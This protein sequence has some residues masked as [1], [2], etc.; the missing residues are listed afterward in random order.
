MRPIKRD[1]ALAAVVCTVALLNTLSA[2][3]MP[4]AERRATPLVALLWLGLLL[5]HGAVYELGNRIR[6]RFH[7]SGYAAAQATILFAIA[8][9]RPPA[10]LTIVLFMTAVADLVLASLI[11]S[12]LYRAT[13]NGLILAA[14]GL[15]AHAIAGLLHRPEGSH[16]VPRGEPAGVTTGPL[17]LSTREH[18]VLQELVN[19]A[20]NSD[21][22]GTL[23][24]TERTVKAHLG[25]I[26]RKLG[27]E[28][29][30]AA[31]AAAVQ[32]GLSPREQRDRRPA[33]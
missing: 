24:I 16:A 5:V 17:G 21:I 9:A 20:R 18:E 3:A 28:S 31:V 15:L 1:R 25:S 22:A 7:L 4:V 8:V 13:T 29:R 6:G 30:A 23:G 32:A 12:D 33:R 2:L 10:P 14:T 27:V 11:T 19:G 26:Y